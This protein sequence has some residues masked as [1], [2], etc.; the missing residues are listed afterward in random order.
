MDVNRNSVVD[1]Q[2]VVDRVDGSEAPPKTERTAR[3]YVILA[4]L[5]LG[6]VLVILALA[7]LMQPATA[8]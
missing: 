3:S 6:M 4:A 8:S 1:Y 7:L 2:G 5:M